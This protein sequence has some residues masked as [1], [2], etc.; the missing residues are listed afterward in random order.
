MRFDDSKTNPLNQTAKLKKQ[1]NTLYL[2]GVYIK[3]SLLNRVLNSKQKLKQNYPVEF[4]SSCVHSQMLNISFHHKWV[5]S[6]IYGVL[7]NI[8]YQFIKFGINMQ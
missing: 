5:L 1:K 2:N 3:I 4:P 7:I 6:N 8:Y